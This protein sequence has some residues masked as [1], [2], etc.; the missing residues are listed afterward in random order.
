M[1]GL[2]Y[3][4]FRA[5]DR[6]KDSSVRFTCNICSTYNEAAFSEFGRET[7]NCRK[8]RSNIRLRSII[9]LLSLSLFGESFPLNEFPENKNIKGIGMSDFTPYARIL[10]NKL[11][12]T[13]T[14]YHQEPR[15]DVTKISPD[16]FN[17]LDFIIS[18]EVF[19]HIAPPVSIA[20]DNV[21]KILKKNGKFI[22]TVPFISEGETIE[23]FPDL[24]NYHI[25][26]D[27][28]GY[29]MVNEKS[30][31]EK[32]IF[33]KLIFHG[34]P[35]ATL[36]MRIFSRNG[37]VEE[38]KRAGFTDIQIIEDNCLEYGICWQDKWSLP[39][40]ATKA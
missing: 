14:Y 1:K 11:N 4:I 2:F 29:K 5:F 34:G 20:F 37:V 22:F 10:S 30:D 7:S 16:L 12:Y 25:Y 17:S 26:N 15:F 23:H 36:E 18:S 31:G 21:Y 33:D 13:N 27:Q 39:I 19:E 3:K 38:L 24:H 9:H 28:D 6:H 8:C 32:E 40:V 35:G